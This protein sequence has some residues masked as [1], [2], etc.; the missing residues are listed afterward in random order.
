[1][2]ASFVAVADGDGDGID[3]AVDGTWDGASFTDES[4]F[5]SNSFTD[6]HSGGTTAGT[7]TDRADLTITVV[8]S[9]DP[10]GLLVSASG[11]GIGTAVVNV[12]GFDHDFSAG[13]SAIVTVGS[14]TTDVLTGPVEIHLAADLYLIVPSGTK[15]VVTAYPNDFLVEC[16][17]ASAITVDKGGSQ[18]TIDPGNS[19]TV[20][21]GLAEL[22]MAENPDA[23]GD[24][25]PTPGATTVDRGTPQAISTTVSAG[26]LFAGWT[27]APA[28]NAAFDNAA[29]ES[30]N[31]TLSGDATVTANYTQVFTLLVA[32][33]GSGAVTS[34]P[35]GI[36]CGADCTEIFASGT[37]V[38]LTPAAGAG[39]IFSGWTGDADCF[40]GSVVMTG[41]RSCTASFSL[42]T[43]TL[44]VSAAGTGFGSVSSSLAGIDCGADCTE[45]YAGGTTVT[46]TAD[47]ALRSFFTGWG[48]DADCADGVVTMT[49]DCSCTAAFSAM[50]DWNLDGRPDMAFRNPGTGMNALLY[51]DGAAR[52]GIDFI[53]P[54][55]TEWQ[56]A[57]AADLDDDGRMDLIFRNMASG[58]HV[59]A[60]FDGTSYLGFSVLPFRK[61]PWVLAGTADHNGDDKTDFFWTNTATGENEVAYLSG[62]AETGTDTLP[63]APLPWQVV[64][65]D[66]FNGD[67]VPDLVARHAVNGML[68]V[69]FL[70]GTS[71]KGIGLLP[72]PALSQEV[73][74]TMDVNMDGKPDI[75]LSD[76]ET[77]R[78]E[79]WYMDG[80]KRIGLPASLP[81]APPPWTGITG[82]R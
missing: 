57:G 39:F 33:Q 21:S 26:Y 61:A 52:T 66:D 30:T 12:D 41:D 25:T 75:V 9:P 49:A 47:P 73:A 3:D 44:T 74:G 79:V 81:K 48:G 4:G 8:E 71:L 24:T 40:D 22:T 19:Q 59:A 58:L 18:T 68:A 38:T 51:L 82:Y 70:D 45:T 16:Q 20:A 65:V 29:A 80:I 64:A 1:V 78:N 55:P 53:V 10:T 31:V 28:A 14:L 11:G 77:G 50:G 62:E 34:V 76:P 60:H 46:L 23:G 6:Q 37:N 67:D 2:T 56:M 63:T 54:A 32:V 42:N 13:D 69:G 7:I 72:A 36:D 43:F 27:A 5:F 17:G 15:A 35:A